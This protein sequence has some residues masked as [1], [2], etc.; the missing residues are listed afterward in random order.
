MT[1]RSQKLQDIVFLI[2]M[3][4]EVTSE[5]EKPKI[6]PNGV[7]DLAT[8][9]SFD[10]DYIILGDA[11]KNL[12]L[13]KKCDVE[14][15]KQEKQSV[16]IINF[17]KIMQNKMEAHAIGAYSLSKKLSLSE[18]DQA[19]LVEPEPGVM[20]RGL[21]RHEQVIPLTE[22]EKK[23]FTIM[24]AS[25]DGYI[26]LWKIKEAKNLVIEAQIN[27]MDKILSTQALHLGQIEEPKTMGLRTHAE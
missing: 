20:T 27:V 12:T 6:L 9:I 22:T 2:Y 17:K 21:G 14:D 5:I 23:L 11:S 8:C 15:N 26:R 13:L 7:Q 3:F 19:K 10:G 25:F 16:D 24:A 1:M 18:V 4:N